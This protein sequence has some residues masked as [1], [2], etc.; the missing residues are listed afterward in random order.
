MQNVRNSQGA[1]LRYCIFTAKTVFVTSP[2]PLNFNQ[3]PPNWNLF[4]RDSQWDYISMRIDDGQEKM[5][6]MQTIRLQLRLSSL[7]RHKKTASEHHDSED[8]GG[9]SYKWTVSSRCFM[10]PLLIITLSKDKMQSENQLT[11]S[12]PAHRPDICR[13]LASLRN[14]HTLLSQSRSTA[15]HLIDII[16]STDLSYLSP[17]MWDWYSRPESLWGIQGQ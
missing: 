9:G 16:S 15:S 8:V 6:D 3:Y 7:Q 12:S 11:N 1:L 10:R 13:Q 17:E 5:D 14:I 2:W 4:V